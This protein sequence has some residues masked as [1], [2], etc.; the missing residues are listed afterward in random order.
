ME[1]FVKAAQELS[2]V[3]SQI[4]WINDQLNKATP[5]QA[6]ELRNRLRVEDRKLKAWDE[7]HGISQIIKSYGN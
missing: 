7:K 4:L 2:E 1:E 5:K 3:E 6:T